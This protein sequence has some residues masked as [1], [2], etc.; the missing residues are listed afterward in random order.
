MSLKVDP[1]ALRAWAEWLTWLSEEVAKFGDQTALP[2]N[3]NPD[4]WGRQLF[5]GTEFDA[6]LG[7]ADQAI[8]KSY[9]SFASRQDELATI[10]KGVKKDYEI[11][12]FTFSER[13]KAIGGLI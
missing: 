5:P 12:D 11:T 3:A 9:K 6:A 10:A 7:D 1:D 2:S 8:K 13:L 4:R